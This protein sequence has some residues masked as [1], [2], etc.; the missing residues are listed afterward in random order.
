MKTKL[1]LYI[2]ALLLVV[3]A[4]RLYPEYAKTYGRW[5]DLTRKH[6]KELKVAFT[7]NRIDSGLDDWVA[8][9]TMIKVLEYSDQK[10]Q[11]LIDFEGHD[12]YMFYYAR[13]SKS[14]KWIL[15]DHYLCDPGQGCAD[16]FYPLWGFFYFC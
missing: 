16:C 11:A 12:L 6:G 9:P 15:K 10:A 5:E 8:E 3:V 14:G 2:L 13:D 4:V 7:E 1:Y